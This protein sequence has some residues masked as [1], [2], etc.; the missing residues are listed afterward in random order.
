MLARRTDVARLLHSRAYR[1]AT[2][3]VLLTGSRL[4]TEVAQDAARGGGGGSGGSA[5]S[6]LRA[7]VLLL[8]DGSPVPVGLEADRVI[9][10]SRDVLRKARAALRHSKSN[11]DVSHSALLCVLRSLRASKTVTAWTR[12]QS[13]LSRASQRLV[14]P[15][16]AQLL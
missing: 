12:L 10:A 1:D 15:R 4:L 2:Q 8:A 5:Q 9:G 16:C 6:P 11:S 13:C 3:S 7:R 14:S